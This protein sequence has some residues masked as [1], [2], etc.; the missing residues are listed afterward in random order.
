M[1][2]ITKDLDPKDRVSG[3][4][5]FSNITVN[6]L[7]VNA[8]DFEAEVESDRLVPVRS[9]CTAPVRFWKSPKGFEDYE[10]RHASQ[11]GA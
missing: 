9:S 4:S 8:A 1:V 10:T 5:D 3:R 11:A 7:V 6:G 2:R